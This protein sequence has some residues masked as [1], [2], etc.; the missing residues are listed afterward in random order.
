MV[1][2]K[3]K[4]ESECGLSGLSNRFWTRLLTFPIIRRIFQSSVQSLV[5][6]SNHSSSCS[7]DSPINR[8]IVSAGFCIFQDSRNQKKKSNLSWRFARSC[9]SESLS[10]PQSGCPYLHSTLES[11]RHTFSHRLGKKHDSYKARCASNINLAGI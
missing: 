4:V 6:T 9:S 3:T 7:A 11:P 5:E 1:E 8:P 2:E 10:F